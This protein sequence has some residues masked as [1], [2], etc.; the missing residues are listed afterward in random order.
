[1]SEERGL[2]GLESRQQLSQLRRILDAESYALLEL[3]AQ[4]K[5]NQSR[6]ARLLGKHRNTIRRRLQKIRR[7][8][9]QCPI[10]NVSG[11]LQLTAEQREQLVQMAQGRNAR[12]AFKARLIV[13]LASGQSYSQIEQAFRTSAPTISR[14]KY[15]FAKH[16]IDGLNAKYTGRKASSDT[17]I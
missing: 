14:W 2:G 9:R 6:V 8:L 11:K 16:G 7:V 4:S 5:G 17:R 3:L 10:R 1:G 13:A 15:R 12:A